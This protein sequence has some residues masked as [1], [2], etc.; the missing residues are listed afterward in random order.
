[1]EGVANSV[2]LAWSGILCCLDSLSFTAEPEASA[3]PLPRRASCKVVTDPGPGVFH[4]RAALTDVELTRT[5]ANAALMAGTA[6]ASATVAP[7]VSLVMPRLS[8][9]RA[10]IEAEMVDSRSGER[11]VGL[12]TSKEGRRFF[13]GLRGMQKSS[14]FEVA[15]KYWAN[16]FR[17]RLDQFHG[18]TGNK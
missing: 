18:L 10:S 3:Y 6:A 7:D 8:V 11:M 1:M 5:K 13:S 17:E 15:C 16:A 9:G 14:D 2:S 12:V 4:L